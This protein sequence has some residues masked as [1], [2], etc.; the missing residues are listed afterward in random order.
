MS[1]KLI[2]LIVS[3]TLASVGHAQFNA[4]WTSYDGATN[5]YFPLLSACDGGEPLPD[6]PNRLL[7]RAAW[8]GLPPPTTVGRWAYFI[9]D[10]GVEL[11]GFFGHSSSYVS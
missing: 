9:F 4:C 10:Y 11:L 2:L 3:L 6:G 5:M 8:P 7:G 1:W